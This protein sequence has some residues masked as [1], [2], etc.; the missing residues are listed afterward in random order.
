M[1]SL[2]QDK[3]E[4]VVMI[5][6]RQL[7]SEASPPINDKNP[8]TEHQGALLKQALLKLTGLDQATMYPDGT[9]SPDATQ[10]LKNVDIS[11]IESQLLE[12]QT[13]T[14]VSK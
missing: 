9:I 6:N 12:P 1:G 3:Y 10:K 8:I 14:E 13:K 4:K 2:G 7:R 11:R 5:L